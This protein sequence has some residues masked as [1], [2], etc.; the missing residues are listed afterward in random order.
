MLN[1]ILIRLSAALH[2]SSWFFDC[3][4]FYDPAEEDAAANGNTQREHEA[5]KN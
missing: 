3:E 1:I 5:T 4:L 2:G